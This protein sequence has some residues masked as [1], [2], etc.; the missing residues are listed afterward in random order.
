MSGIIIKNALQKYNLSGYMLILVQFVLGWDN[1]S[2][3]KSCPDTVPD[4]KDFLKHS[5]CGSMTRDLV[6]KLLTTLA[7]ECYK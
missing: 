1:V 2:M 4:S 6:L 7:T 5:I 3:I